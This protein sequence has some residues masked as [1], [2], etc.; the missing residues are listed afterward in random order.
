MVFL[1]G[2]EA[3]KIPVFCRKHG[4]GR[5]MENEI[6][7]EFN[8]EFG[9]LLGIFEFGCRNANVVTVALASTVGAP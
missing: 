7:W 3:G 4:F 5:G 1:G 6:E 9:F 8:S 2:F